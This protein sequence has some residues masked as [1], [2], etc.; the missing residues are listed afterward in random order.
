MELAWISKEQ[1]QSS[2]LLKPRSFDTWKNVTALIIA[3]LGYLEIDIEVSDIGMET[4]DFNDCKEMLK[5]D[6]DIN[7][8]LAAIQKEA[9]FSYKDKWKFINLFA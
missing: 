3:I 7:N 9:R 2:K 4:T 8:I 5:N 6:G 1:R